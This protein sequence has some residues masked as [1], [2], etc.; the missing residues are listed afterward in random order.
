[1]LNEDPE[2]DGDL[3]S[4]GAARERERED[5]LAACTDHTSEVPDGSESNDP[6]G[7]IESI[8][9][10]GV[11]YKPTDYPVGSGGPGGKPTPGQVST[12]LRVPSG[13]NILLEAPGVIFTDTSVSGSDGARAISTR[14][15]GR[16]AVGGA[17]T[18]VWQFNIKPCQGSDRTLGGVRTGMKYLRSAFDAKYKLW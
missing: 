17:Q 9:A 13:P 4:V 1:M 3:P 15:G 5:I 7:S 12:E 18:N 11:R 16:S 14:E 6:E 2:T 8:L 10:E